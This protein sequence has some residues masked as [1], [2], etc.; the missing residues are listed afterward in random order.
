MK[1]GSFAV[2]FAVLVSCAA[3]ASAAVQFGTPAV[4]SNANYP[5][6]VALADLNGDGRP[7]VA[8]ASYTYGIVSVLMNNGDGTFGVRMNIGVGANPTGLAVADLN[9]DGW[10]DMAVA[11]YG[12]NT[13]SVMLNNGDG[14]LSARTDYPLGS[15]PNAVALGDMNGDGRSDIV[16]VNYG[17][18][19]V[20]VLLNNGDGTFGA[21]TDFA[22]AAWPLSVALGD[23]NGDGRLDLVI[24]NGAVLS[25]LPG[26]GNGTFGSYSTVALALGGNGV[27]LGDLDGDG[28][29]DVAVADNGAGCVSVLM[30]NGNMTFG[31]RVDIPV[32][33]ALTSVKIADMDGDGRQDLVLGDRDGMSVL[34]G[35]GNGSFQARSSV[36]FGTA[37]Q[38]RWVAVGDV[39][40]DGRPDVAVANSYDNN[41]AVLK[42]TSPIVGKTAQF[43]S[44]V[45]APVSTA[46]RAVAVADFNGDGKP[47][48][49]T[50]NS[51][52]NTISVAF[53]NGDGTYGPTTD[54]A[55]GAAPNHVLAA[56]L[57][58]DG[59]PD[60]AVVNYSSN[61]VS[62][63]L[64]NGNGT[65]GAKTDCTVGSYPY[66]LAI[67]DLNGDG[68]PDIAVT[69][70]YSNTVSVLYNNGA[71]GFGARADYAAGYNPMAIAIG[72]LNGDGR[73]DLIVG[74]YAGHTIAILPGTG[75][76][77]FGA[78]STVSV[79][80]LPWGVT[81][82]DV[83]GDGKLDIVAA[84]QTSSYA[85][86]FLGN[87]NLTFQGRLDITT[88]PSPSN[89]V[90]AD[91]N[92]DGRPDLAL[93]DNN[94]VS[95]HL[96]YG[97]GAF[98]PRIGIV[99]GTANPQSHLVASGDVNGDGRP[100]LVVTD[101]NDNSVAVL[102]NLSPTLTALL[103]APNPAVDGNLVLL[104]ATVTPATATGTVSFLVGSTVLGTASLSG[105]V[106][107]LPLGSW[108]AGTIPLTAR[109]E[110][111]ATYGSSAS[112]VT[113]EV[114]VIPA[115]TLALGPAP[116]VLTLNNNGRPIS[117]TA[118][119]NTVASLNGFSVI[120]SVSPALYVNGGTAGFHD[121]TYLAS[122]GAT[123]SLLVY[124][125]GFSGGNHL[126]E[127]DG[128][129][130]SGACGSPAPS[131][132]MF[133][134]DIGGAVPGGSGTVSMQTVHMYGCDRSLSVKIGNPATF[135]IDLS[136]P[137]THVTAPNGGELWHVGS[138][139]T[140]TWTGIDP[141]GVSG[142]T[143]A[144]S[145]DGG[146]TYPNTIVTVPPGQ[147]YYGW[148]VPAL[149]TN[150]ARIRVWG[151]DVN[152]NPGVDASDANFTLAYYALAY[153]AGPGG[154]ISG[155]ASQAVPW[156]GS[157]TT[158]TAVP[159]TGFHFAG[160]SDGVGTAAR[161]EA[162]VTADL[163]VTAT[164]AANP[165]VIGLTNLRATQVRTG[166]PA[167][168]T[169]GVTLSWDTTPNTVEVW[170]KGYGSY[171]EYDDAGGAVPTAS[172]TYPPGPGWTL[173]SVTSPGGVDLT[174]TRDYYY[175]AAYQRDSYGTWSPVATTTGALNYHLA[176]VS[177]G[178]VT[179]VGDN[180]VAISDVSALGS[181]YGLSGSA[182]AA[183]AYLDVG[184]T[185]TAWIDGRPAT[186][187]LIAFEDLVIFSLNFSA[188]SAPAMGNEP[189]PA[190]AVASASSIELEAPG[191]AAPG[192]TVT[193]RL[194]MSGAGDL[195]ALSTKLAWD[196]GVVQPVG[197]SAGDWLASQD[198][199]ALSATPGTVD[200]AV[201]QSGGMSGQGELAS[202]T[203]RVLAAGDPQIRIASADG[204]DAANRKVTVATSVRPQAP[205]TTQLAAPRPNPFT[206][207]AT[208]SFALAK[209]GPV[210]VLLYSVDGRKVR[211]LARD[212]RA[213]GEYSL[214]WDGRDESGSTVPAGVYYLYLN[215]AQGQFTRTVTYLK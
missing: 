17:S 164:F 110:G 95:L 126:Y 86:V 106:A 158:V 182:V 166:N 212:D 30:G 197:L 10:P 138:I 136:A 214:T 60:I 23:L 92:G 49:V 121:G 69:N 68:K 196:P 133:T 85:A 24:G 22:T 111:N 189:A 204:R 42:N 117:V 2:A 178:S 149:A 21:R 72:D 34:P 53:G 125:L 118:T 169:T 28:R 61:S 4:Y 7:E 160:W 201:M 94:G 162:S 96:G 50:A 129:R 79:A 150:S 206:Q 84:D 165:A 108:G 32:T 70:F 91:F 113:N 97:N 13:V 140:I 76:G 115:Y 56:D 112:S 205:S 46:P 29:L 43:G 77:A 139:Q 71:G 99:T 200:A 75:G 20:S 62:V 208:V 147:L 173:T 44:P 89:V 52:A 87:G 37:A 119:R 83:N 55:A 128:G 122:T 184:P 172:A 81:L 5:D 161:T 154:T 40:G 114:L 11:N 152:G 12:S 135:T 202:V 130:L 78:Y 67:G 116:P 3:V 167:G 163:S 177:N 191:A 188:V 151:V 59:K 58:G 157:G 153:S 170:R 82:G 47:D 174:G 36:A 203:F 93:S 213:A 73:M 18:N 103:A 181:S 145:T 199:V 176:D 35:N 98:Y 90:I 193:V 101:Y 137:T 144:Y 134:I 141:E 156:N 15:N 66:T 54:Y 209:A 132:T 102:R 39:N 146:A 183:V 107:S 105:G 192:A 187:N 198:G 186:D 168:S 16:A 194:V 100:D 57:N 33:P 48:M 41:V 124:D 143:L 45:Y 148:I 74:D 65:F 25:I 88:G 120:V 175:Y 8:Y 159:N 195:V 14:S 211:T 185:T 171:P 179:G 123:T 127:V 51:L 80:G 180:R 207:S 31:S 210:E 109:Y 142:W 190:G 26:N 6:A 64:N 63:L 19:T 1:P 155:A 27:A 131:G 215:T 9:G 104:T 38:L